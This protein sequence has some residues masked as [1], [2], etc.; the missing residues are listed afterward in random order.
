[1][2]KSVREISTKARPH[3]DKCKADFRVKEAKARSALR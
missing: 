1:M 3:I 2:K